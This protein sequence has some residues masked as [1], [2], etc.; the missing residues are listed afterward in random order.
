MKIVH[1]YL[2]QFL[3][4]ITLE[5]T[6]VLLAKE[7]KGVFF[8]NFYASCFNTNIR[9]IILNA[10]ETRTQHWSDTQYYSFNVLHAYIF[11]LFSYKSGEETW[12]FS[13]IYFCSISWNK[14]AVGQALIYIST[15]ASTIDSI[16][17][18]LWQTG[19]WMRTFENKDLL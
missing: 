1:I 14:R 18:I 3:Y 13:K 7:V 4:F 12:S 9:L 2:G 10:F 11:Y 16:N 15:E 17:N 6:Y 5:I 19:C 8:F